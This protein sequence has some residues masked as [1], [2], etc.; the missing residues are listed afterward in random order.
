VAGVVGLLF[1]VFFTASTNLRVIQ[2]D[3]AFKTGDVFARPDSWPVSIQVYN[4][5]RDLAPNEDYYY[6]FLGRAYLEYAKTIENASDRE[7]LINQAERDLLEAQHINPLNTDHTA[8]LA[9]LY[10]LWSGFSED[11]IQKAER[12]QKADE[13]F[14]QAVSLS[15]QSA[16]LW[17]EWAVHAMNNL[18]DPEAG[19]EHLQRA[20]EID[21]YYDWSYG[22]LG[23]YY[24]RFES[25]AADLTL[26]QQTQA[27]VQAADYYTKAVSL[28]DPENPSQGYG[29]L[30]S[31]GS[32]QAQVGDLQQAIQ[33][34]VRAL[35]LWPENPERWRVEAAVAQLYAQLSDYE[36]ALLYAQQA[37]ATAPEDQRSA[38]EEMIKQYGGQS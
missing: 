2:A 10:S 16:R 8:N 37:L 11:P 35:D 32:T 14:A 34:Y 29:Y 36:A 18:N 20:I 13:Y 26:E 28:M 12:A 19:F 24:S 22:L 5:A 23:D 27:L 17:D 25:A 38:I 1:A 7:Q 9:R 30:I 21:P 33:A 31:Y 15:P 4:R 6:L 3:I